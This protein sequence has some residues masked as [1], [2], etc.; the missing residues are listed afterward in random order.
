MKITVVIHDQKKVKNK[1]FDKNPIIASQ[2]LEGIVPDIGEHNED[3]D[4]SP[5]PSGVNNGGEGEPH[6]SDDRQGSSEEGDKDIIKHIALTDMKKI[7]FVSDKNSGEYVV[8]IDSN[9][10][11]SDCELEMYYF[12]DADN[13]YTVNIESCI[14]N[15]QE[16]E[17]YNGRPVKF[18]ILP[19]KT[20]I[21]LKTDLRD[22]YRCEVK[23]YANR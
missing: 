20:K 10:N 8:C 13:Q 12:D 11:E 4:D 19:G 14:V 1:Q 22:Y 23:L 2:E 15:G 9:Y 16:S 3:G 17:I 5:I 21:V 7:F 6:E 18:K